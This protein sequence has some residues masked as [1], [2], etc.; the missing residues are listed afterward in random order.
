MSL[1]RPRLPDDQRR[2]MTLKIRVTEDENNAIKV[3]GGSEWAR[4]VLLRAAKRL[5]AANAIATLTKLAEK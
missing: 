1:G 2:T 5:A 3:A 4:G